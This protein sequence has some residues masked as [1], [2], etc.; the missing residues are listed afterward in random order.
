[1]LTFYCLKMYLFFLLP[2]W[3]MNPSQMTLSDPLSISS[4]GL[5]IEY[6]FKKIFLHIKNF[7]FSHVTC[8]ISQISLRFFHPFFQKTRKCLFKIPPSA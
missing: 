6:F 5:G 2:C 4:C 8:E 3:M 1:M 7:S